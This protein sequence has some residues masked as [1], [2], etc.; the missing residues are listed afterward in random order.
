M[1]ERLY[2]RFTQ[3]S[4]IYGWLIAFLE[5]LRNTYLRNKYDTSKDKP[6]YIPAEGLM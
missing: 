4:T 3:S 5:W 6:E 1:L 2:F